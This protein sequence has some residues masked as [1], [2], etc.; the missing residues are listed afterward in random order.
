M[1]CTRHCTTAI[2]KSRRSS[3]P[4]DLRTLFDEYA[5]A[6]VRGEQPHV[7]DYLARAGDGA[8]ELG[9]LLEAFLGAAPR[10]QADA[11][12]VAL[13]SA[14]AENEPPLV[15]LRAAR[16]VRVDEVVDA[17]VEEAGLAPTAASKVKR[18]YQRLEQGRLD[19][20]GVSERVWNVLR[21]LIGPAADTAA[22]WHAG[23]PAPQAAF[24]RAAAPTPAAAAGMAEDRLS[25]DRDEVD[26][27]FTSRA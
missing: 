26:E 21:R 9:R 2:S 7:R 3:V 1:P 8:D 15:H 25:L 19:A 27:L 20:S 16:G 13:V 18:Y 14:W 12:T 23:P 17:I 24:Y 5:T 22:A 4:E 11:D 10:P 6:Y